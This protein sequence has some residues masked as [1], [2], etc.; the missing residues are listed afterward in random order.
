MY[1]ILYHG[2]NACENIKKNNKICDNIV[3]YV[4]EN[5]LIYWW[6]SAYKKRKIL[7]KNPNILVEKN[8][9]LK[10]HAISLNIIIFTILSI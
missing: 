10:E 4:I 1:N 9:L 3:Y 6:C 5:V 8:K 7:P 2:K